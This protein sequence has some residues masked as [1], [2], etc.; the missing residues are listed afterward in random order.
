MQMMGAV[1]GG[2]V[3]FLAVQ[4]EAPVGDAIGA[5]SD[6]ATEIRTIALDVTFES[7]E[8]EGDVAEAVVSVGSF[9]RDEGRAVIHHGSGHAVLVAQGEQGDDGMI[10]ECPE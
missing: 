4:M 3:V 2:E 1:V 7:V 6:D 9:E 10:G 5:A 8:A